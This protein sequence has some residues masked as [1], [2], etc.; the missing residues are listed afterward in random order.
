LL[1]R[2]VSKI[3]IATLDVWVGML[4]EMF[5]ENYGYGAAEVEEKT[6]DI[7][8]LAVIW[9]LMHPDFQMLFRRHTQTRKGRPDIKRFVYDL[10]ERATE[11]R[12]R[13]RA[14]KRL[15]MRR[16]RQQSRKPGN[17]SVQVSLGKGGSINE[18]DA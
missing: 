2:A 8:S 11:R 13:V 1:M 12:E 9:P 7:V 15:H 10:L 3:Q 4:K 5:V 18:L 17:S 6:S 14:R 16:S